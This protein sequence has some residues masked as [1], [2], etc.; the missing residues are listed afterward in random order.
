[1]SSAIRCWRFRGAAKGHREGSEESEKAGR[2]ASQNKNGPE[3]DERRAAAEAFATALYFCPDGH[4]RYR[5]LFWTCLE[6][7]KLAATPMR[8]GMAI[9]R[10][11]VKMEC[12]IVSTLSMPFIHRS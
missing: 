11:S 10:V 8:P 9:S 6:I 4:E 7:R 1:M 2:K 5:I 3:M 12:H